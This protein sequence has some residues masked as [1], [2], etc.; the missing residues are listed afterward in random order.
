MSLDSPNCRN[1]LWGRDMCDIVSLFGFT[2]FSHCRHLYVMLS[3]PQCVRESNVSAA[4]LDLTDGFQ[5]DTCS[6]CLIIYWL[7]TTFLSFNYN[8]LHFRN[9]LS[10]SLSKFENDG[11]L[12]T[13]L[14]EMHFAAVITAFEKTRAERLHI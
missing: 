2:D 14:D 11:L 7:N 9:N 4:L 12:K 8:V 5:I 13:T 3:L 1:L 6:L 10:N